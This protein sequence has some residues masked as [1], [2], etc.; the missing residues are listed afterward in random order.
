[1][2]ITRRPQGHPPSNAGNAATVTVARDAS[3]L[4]IQCL[5]SSQGS[6]Y[7]PPSDMWAVGCVAYEMATFKTP[8]HAAK[9]LPDLC[10]RICNAEV[11]WSC[12]KGRRHHATYRHPVRCRLS[13]TACH[14]LLFS[15]DPCLF[16]E[17]HGQTG[18]YPH[19]GIHIC[20]HVLYA[21]TLYAVAGLRLSALRCACLLL[22]IAPI[23]DC[24]S[25][26]L[27]KIVYQMLDRCPKTRATAPEILETPM[28][29]VTVTQ[30]T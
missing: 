12:T 16:L 17:L 13:T 27:S 19:A 3:S 4:P 10:Y 18:I 5:T 30:K 11:R 23:P 14:C 22:Q 24:Y 2:F 7:G 26:E 6:P 8:F 21:H 1:M 29:Q 20:P 15:L 28:M 9:N 25:S